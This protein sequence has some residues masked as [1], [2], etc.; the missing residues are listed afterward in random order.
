MVPLE[1]RR[2]GRPAGIYGVKPE[3]LRTDAVARALQRAFP[4]VFDQ[5]A[6]SALSIADLANAF[7]ADAAEIS[8]DEGGR[9]RVSHYSTVATRESAIR[10]T[11]KRLTGRHANRDHPLPHDQ[12]ASLATYI[13]LVLAMIRARRPGAGRGWGLELQQRG[14][15][16][17]AID[18]LRTFARHM[19]EAT[20]R[21]NNSSPG[22]SFPVHPALV[23]AMLAVTASDLMMNFRKNYLEFS[24]PAAAV[25]AFSATVDTET[26]RHI[27]RLARENLPVFP[28]TPHFTVAS[29]ALKHAAET[30]ASINRLAADA[31]PNDRT[32]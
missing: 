9:W 30:M 1:T 6:P 15:P 27:A 4:E 32:K 29:D 5:P 28:H 26:L 3:R 11:Q 12:A 21:D 10:H 17:H 2:R 20:L 19:H 7:L 14:W 24:I 23:E 31:F 18:R 16:S 8:W 25:A 22:I 13:D